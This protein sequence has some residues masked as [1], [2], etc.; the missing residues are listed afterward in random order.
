[1]KHEPHDLT[2]EEV[3]IQL[4]EGLLGENVATK[5]RRKTNV[6][7]VKNLASIHYTKN[8]YNAIKYNG[9]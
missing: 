2:T 9:T 8:L 3:I 6:D 7:L 4:L 1:M 5:R